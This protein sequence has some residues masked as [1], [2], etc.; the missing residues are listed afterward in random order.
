MTEVKPK[1]SIVGATTTYSYQNKILIAVESSWKVQL[2]IYLQLPS[3]S[4]TNHTPWE[5]LSG[6]CWWRSIPSCHYLIV[7]VRSLDLDT[8]ARKSNFVDTREAIV[9]SVLFELSCSTSF[10]HSIPQCSPPFRKPY[11]RPSADV[12]YVQPLP[13]PYFYPLIIGRIVLRQSIVINSPP[14]RPLWPRLIMRDCRR[15]LW[16]K[17]ERG[18]LREV[19]GEELI[20]VCVGCKVGVENLT[21]YKNHWYSSL[22]GLK[23]QR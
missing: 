3:K 2:R 4:M 7:A 13:L 12:R 23:Y 8:I 18:K 1:I 6:G 17:F 11:P 14:N 5:T 16:T 22:H 9:F 10:N 21:S 20:R 15:C 19:G